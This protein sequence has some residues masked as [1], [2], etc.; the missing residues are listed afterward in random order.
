[1]PNLAAIGG[2]CKGRT[3]RLGEAAVLGRS[4]EADVRLDDPAISRRHAQIFLISGGWFIEDLGSGNGTSV[5]GKTIV[6]PTR[7]KSGDEIG[8]AGN[9]FRFAAESEPALESDVR[10]VEEPSAAA[11]VAIETLDVRATSMDAALAQRVTAPDALIKAQQRFRVVLEI[12]NAVQT[13][14]D[15]DK[16]L[17]QIM[18]QLFGVFPHADR[19]FIMLKAEESEEFVS[20]VSKQRGREQPEAIATSGTI[21]RR[22]MSDRVALLSADAMGDQRFAMAASV[23]NFRIRSMMCAPIV[24]RAS[25]KALGIIH[26][27][28]SRQDRQFTP[29]DLD[30]LTMA[31]N[32]TAFAI[33]NARM[34]HKL[35]VQ[36]RTER[37]LQLA[38]HVQELFLPRCFPEVAGMQG[39]ASYRPALEVGGDFYDFIPLEGG[40]LGIVIGD[41]VGKG[42]PAALMMARMSSAVREFAR[43]IEDPRGVVKAA[44]ECLL[45]MEAEEMFIPLIFARLDPRSRTLQMVNAGHPPLLLRKGSTGQVCEIQGCDNFPIGIKAGT[46]FEAESFRIEPGDLVCLYSDGITEAM[47][48]QQDGYGSKRLKSVAALPAA[49]A[50]QL[51][52]NI[53]QDVQAFVGGAHRSDDLT[54]VCFGAT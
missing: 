13:Q 25:E 43:T 27:D 28:T 45:A 1:M 17:H 10:I 41:V 42:I 48:A 15:M 47:N 53:L 18:D 5:N 49:S 6:G 9:L 38:R 39:R 12:S 26:L 50:A 31:A 19:G 16:L 30:L 8:L 44:N 54:L 51:M 11:P 36:E 24:E 32:Q 21:L 37:D 35:L 4:V 2:P 46:E 34:H 3:F 22:A 7:L 23:M 29:D 14:L 20:H 52:E 40:H 33:A